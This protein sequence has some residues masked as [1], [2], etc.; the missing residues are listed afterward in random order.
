MLVNRYLRDAILQDLARKMV[1]LGGP[2]QVGKT[3][4]AETVMESYEQP[5]YLNY[6][7]L[8]QRKQMRE[9]QWS[10]ENQLLVFDELHKMPKWKSWI[11]GIYDVQK[12]EHTF[13][14]TGSAKLDIFRRGGDSLLGRYHYWRIHPFT[15]DEYPKDLDFGEVVKRLLS[16]GGFPEPFLTMDMR[17]SH[18]W[19]KDRFDRVLHDDLRSIDLVRDINSLEVLVDLLRE[20]VTSCLS[21]ANIARDLEVS[22]KTV[23]R[24]IQSLEK[25]Y[26]LFT[27]YPYV[28]KGLSRSLS[29]PAKAYFY[30]NGD[31]VGDDG[32]VFENLVAT[33]L[34]KRL[35]WMED[36]E[37]QRCAL[38]YLRDK[39]GR[40]CDF[41]TLVN[42]K[43]DLLIEVKLRDDGISDGLKYY[44][45][46]IK[47]RRAIQLVLHLDR[48]YSKGALEVHDLKSFLKS[49]PAPWGI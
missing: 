32:S 25:L 22:P 6:D 18:R 24:W 35:H 7:N 12:K 9:E 19:R 30:D 44:A 16:L 42:K 11:K 20:R 3:S 27:I 1:F 38:H 5:L 17:Q 46:R 36:F 23:S 39:D 28:A 33:T 41:L 21:S 48:P 2:R 40:E 26:L 49:E 13:L 10:K 14:V 47:P 34:L 31:V 4:L 43:P 29:K 45:E 37:G 15:I 8:K